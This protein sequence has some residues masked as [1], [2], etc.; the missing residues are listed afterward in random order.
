[1]AVYTEVSDESLAGFIAGH[2][3]GEL[4]FCKGIAEGVENT[5]YMVETDM[6]AL[7]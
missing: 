6:A 4:R 3:L 1:M 5:N 2:G 7:S